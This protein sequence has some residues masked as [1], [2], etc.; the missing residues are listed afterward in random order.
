MEK[1]SKSKAIDFK[2]KKYI[3]VKERIL[4]L[5]DKY[6]WKYEIITEYNYFEKAKMWVVKA[7]L[8]LNWMRYFW[9]WQEIEGTTFIN[10]T[11][12]L[13]N[14]ETSAVGRACAMAWIWII[15]SIASADEV[16]KSKNRWSEPVLPWF[17]KEQFSNW[18]KAMKDWKIKYDNFEEAIKDIT[19]KYKI[20]KEAKITLEKAFI[21]FKK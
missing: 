8:I 15:D 3:E 16:N 11:S 10:K 6:E 9:H 18:E 12:A 7:E 17:N 4:F 13:E 2:W 19:K 20:S 14:A 5:A 21:N 1:I